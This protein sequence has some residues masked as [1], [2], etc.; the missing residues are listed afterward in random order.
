[1]V[2]EIDPTDIAVLRDPFTAYGQARE[3]S[4]LA[5]L[6][7][8]GFGP[9]WVVTRLKE[10]RA[11]LSDPRF[12]LTAGSFMPMPGVPDD[13]RPYL[14]TM[15]EMDGQEHVRLRTLVAPA[16]TARRAAEFRPRI[17][18]IVE[19]LLDELPGHADADSV[20]LLRHFAR[21]LPM[22]IICELV[23]IPE[24]D[25]PQWRECG[26]A[27][28]GGFG[29]AFLDSIPAI[30]AGAKAA[31]ARHRVDL[32]DDLLSDLVRAQAQDGDRLS[33]T[34]MVTIVWHLVLAGQTPTNVIANAMAALLTHP[35]Q[36]AALRDDPS[37]IPGAVDELM[38]WCGSQLLTTP[39]FAREDI[40]FDGELI[41]KGERVTAAIVSANRDPRAFADPDRLDVTRGTESLGHLAFAHGPHF[42]VGASLARVQIE[43]AITGLL[44]RFPAMALAAD[45]EYTPD[46]GTWRMA[47]LPVTVG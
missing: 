38:R 19:R 20:D 35:D 8:P 26:A 17:E 15:A 33:E 46:P 30:I 3:R 29:Q 39:R 28:A 41:R 22:D 43:I 11:M 4:P 12:K 10:A 14:R 13:C 45:V 7:I 16:F 36:L 24:S 47:A 37:L 18:P 2:P 31:V 27:V 44:R 23:G 32:G 25:R 34:E 42:C 1:V 6:L 21:P 40:E 5:R 9:M